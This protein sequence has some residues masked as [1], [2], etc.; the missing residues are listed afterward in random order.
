MGYIENGTTIAQKLYSKYGW[1]RNPIVA[2]L[3]NAQQESSIDPGNFQGADGDWSQGVGLWQWTP[4][5][6]LQTRAKAIGRTDYLT[7]DCQLAVIDYERK[8]GIQYYSTSSYDISFN[9]FIKST[10]DIE[11]LTYA[12][13]ANY[14]RA[15]TPMMEN[16]LKYAREW[17]NRIDGIIGGSSVIEDAVKWAVGIANDNSHGYD[18]ASRD[19]PDYDCSSLLC[20]AYYKA[21][22]NT[23]PG[24][25][26]STHTMRQVFLNAGFD[27]VT[28]QVS[29]SSGSGL[30]RGDVL[31]VPG[32]HTEMYIGNGQNV[33]ASINEHGGITGGQTG[34]QTGKE[35]QV[36]SYYNYP[37]EYVLRYPGGGISPGGV[38]IVRWIPG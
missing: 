33:A 37:W 19:G 35:I 10:R 38:Y 22:L 36:R 18:Q 16:R 8:Q 32:S 11:W 3:G 20:W 17:D 23:R 30:I 2:V 9:S 28:S 21:G 26:P 5:T 6:N 27:D 7:I 4:G 14:E 31:L 25:T 13:E 24:Y 15:G 34:D 29:L 12:W 1:S